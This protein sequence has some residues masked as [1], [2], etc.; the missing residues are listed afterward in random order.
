[1]S[2]FLQAAQAWTDA[3]DQVALATVVSTKASNDQ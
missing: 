2:S 1:M 3:G